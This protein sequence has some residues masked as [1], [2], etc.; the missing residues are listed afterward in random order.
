MKAAPIPTSIAVVTLVSA[1]CPRRV[2]CNSPQDR[3]CS[4]DLGYLYHLL[5]VVGSLCRLSS[6]I[7]KI[8]KRDSACHSTYF[9]APLV[10]LAVYKPSCSS[11]SLKKTILDETSPMSRVYFRYARPKKRKSGK[12]RGIIFLRQID[13]WT[14]FYAFNRIGSQRIVSKLHTACTVTSVGQH[15]TQRVLFSVSTHRSDTVVGCV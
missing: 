12:S 11:E 6:T 2:R 15:S 5:L 13:N 3:R 9:F 8:E 7:E 4:R 14:T 1:T 10:S